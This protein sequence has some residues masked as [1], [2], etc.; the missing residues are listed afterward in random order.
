[1][2]Q[3]IWKDYYVTLGNEDVVEYNVGCEPSGMYKEIYVGKAWRRPNE[4]T[5][6]VKINDICYNYVKQIMPL[7]SEDEYANMELPIT[8][9][10]HKKV[11]GNWYEVDSVQFVPDWSY[12]YSFNYADKHGLSFPI[13]GHIDNRQFVF[14]TNLKGDVLTAVVT[15][16]NGETISIAPSEDFNNDFNSDFATALRSIG[17][18][19][20]VVD[21]S[22]YDVAKVEI[23]DQVYTIAPGCP[24][25]CL[26][27]LNAYGGW[28]SFL[29]EGGAKETDNI[30]RKSFSRIVDNTNP[31][32]REVVNYQSE[33]AKRMTLNTS[34]LSDEESARM[35]NLL[36]STEVFMH[37]LE[38]GQI[39]PVVL[40][41][42]TT[43]YKTYRN[44]GGKLVNYT[45][46][47]ELA[48]KR[49]RK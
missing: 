2:L 49:V 12:D 11:N 28:D 33:I 21:L 36:N 15:L 46:E 26:Y 17:L 35:H 32:N 23:Q 31:S 44:N 9:Y 24:R 39:V 25:Y 29:I 16:K 14:W 6:R 4:E 13:N 3:P 48:N 30:T 27:Y 1:M 37:D 42:S 19:T 7:L 5:I 18:K 8:F 47:V 20:F 45:I 34:W 43:E 40:T 38:N 10:I 41:N 22:H